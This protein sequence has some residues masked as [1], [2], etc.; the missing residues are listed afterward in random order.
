MTLATCF[1]SNN[2]SLDD[3]VNIIRYVS[4]WVMASM[5]VLFFLLG[6]CG[7]KKSKRQAEFREKQ[8][9]MRAEA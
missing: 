7:G 6:I 1:D 5:G 9:E 3:W 2:L 4:G 8:L